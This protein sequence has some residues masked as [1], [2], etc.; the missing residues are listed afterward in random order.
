MNIPSKAID[1]AKDAGDD[2]GLELTSPDIEALL[3]GAAPHIAAQAL[4][5]AADE[6]EHGNPVATFL[7][8]RADQMEAR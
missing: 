3:K 6:L 8:D 7:N 1:A 2:Y 5:A 4:R